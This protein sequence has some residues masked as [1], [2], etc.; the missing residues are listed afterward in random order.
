M[1]IFKELR[2][3][4]NDAG[5]SIYAVKDVRQDTDEDLDYTFTVAKNVGREPRDA[6]T[7]D[8]S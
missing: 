1:D 2:K 6:R 3:L 7:A 5:V 8:R 4:Y